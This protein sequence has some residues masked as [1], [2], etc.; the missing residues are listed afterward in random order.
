MCAKTTTPESEGDGFETP[1]VAAT[2]QHQLSF[3]SHAGI[4]LAL[5]QLTNR[6]STSSL[7]TH[8]QVFIENLCSDAIELV[9]LQ[10]STPAIN[11]QRFKTVRRRFSSIK[12]PCLLLH[13]F[14]LKVCSTTPLLP[15][16]HLYSSYIFHTAFFSSLS[17]CDFAMHYFLLPSSH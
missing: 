5:F 10:A 8:T 14:A 12:S 16:S 3:N 17:S 4:S 6:Y 15:Y 13:C 7:S 9:K 2:V 1:Q 11:K